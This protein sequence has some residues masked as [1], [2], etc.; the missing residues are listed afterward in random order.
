MADLKVKAKPVFEKKPEEQ[1][2]MS[3][4]DKA[5]IDK[6]FSFGKKPEEP[7]VTMEKGK[8]TKNK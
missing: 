3:A 5:K 2:E 7:I 8:A 4:E 1:S 6:V